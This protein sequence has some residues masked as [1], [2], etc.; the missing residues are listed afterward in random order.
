MKKFNFSTSALA[1]LDGIKRSLNVDSSNAHCG[2]ACSVSMCT[3]CWGGTCAN[4]FTG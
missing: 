4:G 1:Q 3:S 2:E